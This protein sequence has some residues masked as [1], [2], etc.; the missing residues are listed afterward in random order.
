MYWL[1]LWIRGSWVQT[2]SVALYFKH[3]AP[4]RSNPDFANYCKQPRF[5]A[6][7]ANKLQTKITPIVGLL[8]LLLLAACAPQ[9][10]T[11]VRCYDGDTCTFVLPA[12]ETPVRF[13]GFDTPE[14][15]G[16]CE[17]EKQAARE[18]RDALLAIL[19]GARRIEVQQLG[20]GKY[21]RPLM[22]VFADGVDVAALMLPEYFAREYVPKFHRQPW[23][24]SEEME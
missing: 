11:L 16:Q 15:R 12:Y 10:P 23:C 24:F 6:L 9:A 1:G 19:Q 14:I 2:P 18:A 22:R 7:F 13:V 3:L 4:P 5:W 20:R 17:F 8:A 21:G